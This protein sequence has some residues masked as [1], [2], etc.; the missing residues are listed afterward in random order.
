V[1]RYDA[2]FGAA[3]PRPATE[4]LV[5]AETRAGLAKRPGWTFLAER[6]GRPVA[7]AT[8]EPPEAAAWVAG[9]TRPGTTAYLQTM[10]VRPEERGGG[11]GAA[12]IRHVH[13]LLDAP[14][15]PPRSAETRHAETRHDDRRAHRN[16]ER[17]L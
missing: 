12:L 4:S 15:P 16:A 14:G 3:V 6:D 5:R 11:V 7:L 8:V 9:M 1:I 13:G 17:H 2:H 10:F